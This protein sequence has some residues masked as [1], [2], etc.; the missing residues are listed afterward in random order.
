MKHLLYLVLIS[1]IISCT[2]K[3]TIDAKYVYDFGEM[4]I[5]DTLDHSF[6]IKNISNEPLTILGVEGSCTCT[7]LDFSP[8]PVQKGDSAKI[9]VQYIPKEEVGDVEKVMVFEANTSPPYTILKIKGIVTK[10]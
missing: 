2:P 10:E 6:Y 1:S 8:Q 7:I 3:A 4:K 5:S 9:D